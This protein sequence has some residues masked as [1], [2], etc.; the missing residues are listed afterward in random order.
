MEQLVNVENISLTKSHWIQCDE[1][2][3]PAI[4][5]LVDFN[6]III[7]KY[8]TRHQ[9]RKFTQSVIPKHP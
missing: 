5:I 8:N 9:C 6:E 3:H 4:N 7:L 2:M 1:M